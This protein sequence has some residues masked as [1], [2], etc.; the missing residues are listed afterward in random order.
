MYAI[1]SY[2]AAAN[3]TYEVADALY[4]PGSLEKQAVQKGWSEVGIIVEE[5]GGGNGEPEPPGCWPTIKSALGI[6]S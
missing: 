5:P 2:Y 3:M 1:R 6:G 4:G